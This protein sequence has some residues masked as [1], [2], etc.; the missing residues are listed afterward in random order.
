MSE[1][2][3]NY[4]GA[5]CDWYDVPCHASSFASWLWNALLFLPRKAFEFLTDGIASVVGAIDLPVDTSL[6]AGLGSGVSWF[7]DL[8]AA[9]Q[10]FSMV[11][12]ALLARFALKLIPTLGF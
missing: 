7:A 10:G 9:P 3:P 8:T 1:S 2:L 12:G 11:L 5:S 6:I 4:V